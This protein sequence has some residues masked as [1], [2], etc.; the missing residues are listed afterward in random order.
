MTHYTPL[1][2]NEPLLKRHP[3]N[4]IIRRDAAPCA[5]AIFN[6]AVVPFGD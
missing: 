4:P 1:G 2:R 5:N 3:D 6:S